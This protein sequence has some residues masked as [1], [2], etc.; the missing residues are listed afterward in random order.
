MSD[1]QIYLVEDEENL[2]Q[3]LKAYME[4]EGWNVTAFNNG[5]EAA[6]NVTDAPHL[7]ILDIMLPGI[8]GY[9]V[10]R[11]IKQHADTP[12]IFISARDQDLD[13]IVGLEL[14][15]D[16]YLAKPFMPRELVIR[17]KKLLTRIYETGAMAPKKI[18][19]TGYVIDPVAR[20]ITFDDELIN[21][22]SKEMDVLLYL[23]ENLGTSKAREEILSHV[24]GT[25][26]FGSERAVDDVIRRV[27]KK[28]PRLNLETVYGNGYRIVTS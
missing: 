4:Q 22:T 6:R 3:V 27:R 13:R 17:A 8:D 11:K 5:E 26:Y 2:A 20:K 15:S 24:W 25:D 23:I 28:M 18:E 19:I 14:G 12:V 9:E 1:Y 10:L 7:W 16:D 21:L